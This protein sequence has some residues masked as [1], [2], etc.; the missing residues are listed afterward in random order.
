MRDVVTSVPG[1]HREQLVED[2]GTTVLRVNEA[3]FEVRPS[4]PAQQQG[5]SLVQTFEQ[6]ERNFYRTGSGVGEL[7][8]ACFLV[9]LDGGLAF[10]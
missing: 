7:G 5:P 1:V 2:D 3:A 6:G 4:Q 8:P 10:R 9:W